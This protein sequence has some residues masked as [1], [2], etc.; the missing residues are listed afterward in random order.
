MVKKKKKKNRI[1]DLTQSWNQW[2]LALYRRACWK[3]RLQAP[4]HT[5]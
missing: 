1:T 4:P 5:Y 3:C 2:A